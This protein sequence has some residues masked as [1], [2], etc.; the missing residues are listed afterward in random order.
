M[1]AY[2]FLTSTY[3]CL[4][5][6]ATCLDRAGSE[7]LTESLTQRRSRHSPGGAGHPPAPGRSQEKFRERYYSPGQRTG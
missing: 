2:P 3:P 4:S 7:T 5:R 1:P 6:V